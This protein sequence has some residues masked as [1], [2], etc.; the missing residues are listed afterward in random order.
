MFRETGVQWF[1][2]ALV[3]R[4]MVLTGL[5]VPSASNCADDPT[6]VGHVLGRYLQGAI[7]DRCMCPLTGLQLSDFVGST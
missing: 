4:A 1:S 3:F 5:R 7:R 2:L 6:R